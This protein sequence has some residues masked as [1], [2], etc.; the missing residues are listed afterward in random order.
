MRTL[1]SRLLDLVL[2]R[3]REDR[4]AVEIQAHLD[5]LVDEHIANGMSPADARL[6]ARKA[7]GGVDQTKMRY[8][9]QRGLPMLDALGQDI[10]YSVRML[11][12]QRAL[13][14]AA[15]LALGIGLGANNVMFTMLNALLLRD[16]PVPDGH[17]VISLLT[18]DTA[19]ARIRGVSYPDFQDWRAGLTSVEGLLASR[20]RT[21]T[22]GDEG[23]APDHISI[24]HLSGGAFGILRLTPSLG[25]DFLPEEDT[26]GAAPVIILSDALWQRRYGGEPSIL[27]RTVMVADVATTIVGI[28]PAGEAF[29]FASDAWQ[30]LTL[31]PGVT[32]QTRDTRTLTV[33]GRMRPGHTLGTVRAE[34]DTVMAGL[35]AE[36]PDTNKAIVSRVDTFAESQ[37]G[38]WWRVLPALILAAGLVLLV[39]CA[40]T[41]NLLL[42]RAAGRSREIALRV[43][44]GATRSRIVRQLMVE[45]LVLA[46]AAGLVGYLVSI[47]GITFVESTMRNVTTPYWVKYSMDARVLAVFGALCLM[48]PILFGLLPALHLSKNRGGQL[49]KEGTTRSPGGRRIQRWTGGLVVAEIGLSLIVLVCTGI[50]VRTMFYIRDADRAIDL[51]HLVKAEISLPSRY[52]SADARLAFVNRLNDRLRSNP[53]IAAASVAS[54][55][56]LTGVPAHA[57]EL[58]DRPLA[59]GE[60]G[61]DVGFVTVASDYFNALGLSLIRGRMFTD[62]DGAEAAIVNRRF[63]NTYLPGTD[64]LGRQIR[65]IDKSVTDGEGKWL[66]IVGVSPDVRQTV[67]TEATPTVYL[68]YR[69]EPMTRMVLVARTSERDGDA[70]AAMRE[71]LRAADPGIPLTAVQ[72]AAQMLSVRFFTHNLASGI[73]IALGLV[74]L[75]VSA[76][77]LYVMTAHA[78]ATRTQ[79]IGVRMAVGAPAWSI[80]WLI[81][82][83]ALLL[84]GLGC[85]AGVA[86]AY[87]S[88]GVMR[89]FIA[90]TEARDW[91]FMALVAALLASIALTAALV[92][93]LR[94]ARLDPVVAL[95]HE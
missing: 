79:E 15:V 90:E 71:E 35:L 39:A 17:S 94:A 78:V 30:P 18:Y 77:G 36:H 25:R 58:R 16:A 47:A 55:P 27:G 73:F 19:A 81:G 52:A 9:D 11:G 68:P 93:A 62:G 45:S 70:V 64:P 76:G 69:G 60:V 88:L 10:R 2:R 41:A 86:G 48:A 37:N 61:P 13:T 84:I 4:L 23:L 38:G 54:A 57:L 65:L 49:F 53:A 50:L 42:A 44:L 14:S 74:A 21:A 82:R 85:G 56:P 24:T 5:L 7:F 12:K 63:A 95:R 8:R 33:L 72:T 51:D 3:Q 6:A 31:N 59:A 20:S 43:S 40:N 26:A 83:R 34:L 92:P 29:P 46:M 22:L 89:V 87:A 66:T 91:E 1:F 75:L 32:T 80:S 28:M 67:V